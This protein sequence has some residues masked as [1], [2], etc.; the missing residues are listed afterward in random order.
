LREAANFGAAVFGL[1]LVYGVMLI[2]VAMPS[3]SSLSLNPKNIRLE[4]LTTG[5]KSAVELLRSAF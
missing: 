1:F 4:D 2:A 5:V 3:T